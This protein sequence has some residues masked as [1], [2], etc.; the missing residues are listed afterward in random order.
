M[1]ALARNIAAHESPVEEFITFSHHVSESVISTKKGEYVSVWKLAGRSNE[2]IA[3]EDLFRWTKD[4]GQMIRAIGSESLGFY[5]TTIRSR[6]TEFP[7]ATFEQ[8]FCQRLDARYRASVE[9]SRSMANELFLTVVHRP[10]TDKVMSFLSGRERMSDA[11]RQDRQDAALKKMDEYNLAV[12]AAMS[13][14]GPKLLKIY[15]HNGKAFSE[16][17]EFCARLV[18]GE[19]L[20]VPVTRERFSDYLVQNRI[21]FST[22]GEIAE[23]RLPTGEA[24]RCGMLEIFDYTESTEPGH[25]NGLLH[26]D[27]EFILTQSFSIHSMSAAKGF[28]QRHQKNLVDS[29][30]ASVSQ[31]HEISQ[32]L[33]RL[34]AGDFVMGEHH[35]TLL[36]YGET[37]KEVRE[38]LAS[39]R[40]DL[41]NVGLVPRVV[42]LAL[43]AAYWAQVPGNWRFRPRPATITSLNFLSFASFHNFMTGKAE[44]NPWGPA[45]TLFKTTSGTPYYFNFHSTPFAQDSF[46]QRVLGNTAMIGQS[47]Q[48]KTVLLTFL[49]AQAQKLQPTIVAFDK[50]RGMEVAIRAM[51]GCYQA[52]KNGTP[53]G[54][55]PFQLEPTPENLLFLKSLVVQLAGAGGE[56]VTHRDEVEIDH[57]LATVMEHMERPMR[58]LSILLQSLPDPHVQDGEHP[59]V[60]ARL[61]KW[62]QGGELAWVFD[63][64]V[65]VLDLSTH[66]LYGFDVT[67]FLDNPLTRGP[68]M[69]YLV[70]RTRAMLDGRRFIYVY[71]EFWKMLKDQHF[72]DLVLDTQKTIRKENGLNVFASQEPGD[73]RKST[74]AT[75][76]L[77]QCSTFIFLPNP[78]ADR[79]EYMEAFK[80]TDAEFDLIAEDLPE[81]SRRF[82]IKQGGNSVIA[83]LNLRGFDDELLVMSGTPDRAELLETIMAEVGDEPDVWMPIYCARA[84]DVN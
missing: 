39:A 76:I 63:N 57:A 12:E 56:K 15:D 72:A 60:A 84:K 32:M 65:D 45:V 3:I 23:I 66:Q 2:G 21:V 8:T 11:E 55:N 14:Y 73:L 13:A 77:Q 47:G 83:E 6:I 53:T 48:G 75:T 43:E 50:D 31:I 61:R 64:P 71:D 33:D 68:V 5:A 10:V 40:T 16:P 52:L 82:M 67:H 46:G 17:A 81:G 9:N 35:A 27:F 18:N 62:A 54:F 38:H 59:S 42:D 74:V 19:R 1:A 20:R 36:V 51:G 30:D 7:D 41:T 44:K 58:R 29:G 24:R 26:S 25:L 79:E 34:V 28:L 80:L 22:H 70:Y 37:A 49:M 69:T 4:L 78:A